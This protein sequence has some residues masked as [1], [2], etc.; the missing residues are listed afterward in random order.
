MNR[1]ERRE[2]RK[3]KNLVK[4]LYSIII[5]YLPELFNKFQNLT[6]TRHKSYITYEM[7]TICVTRLFG[8]LCGLTTMTNISSDGFNSD[9]CIKN[10]SRICHQDIKELLYW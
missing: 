1:K 4:E 7:K 9:I 10:L 5:K 2:L 8:L 6:D 3:D